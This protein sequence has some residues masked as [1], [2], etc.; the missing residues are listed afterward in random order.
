MIA[1]RAHIILPIDVHVVSNVDAITDVWSIAD[2]W[3][4]GDIR[5]IEVRAVVDPRPSA[6]ARKS[7]AWAIDVPRQGCWSVATVHPKKVVEIV[8]G[9]SA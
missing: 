5:S 7:V 8:G 3:T 9:R 1:N 6:I 4:I 2:V